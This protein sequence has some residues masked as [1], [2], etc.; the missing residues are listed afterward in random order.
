MVKVDAATS[1]GVVPGFGEMGGPS[2]TIAVTC[3]ALEEELAMATQ[4][5]ELVPD[6]P[7]PVSQ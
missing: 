2:R 5:L 1:T 6:N 7:F 4:G 3:P